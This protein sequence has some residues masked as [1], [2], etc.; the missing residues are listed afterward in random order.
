MVIKLDRLNSNDSELTTVYQ[1]IKN[2]TLLCANQ[3]KVNGDTRFWDVSDD[4]STIF[5]EFRELAKNQSYKV[6]G[7][8]FK[9]TIL[10]VNHITAKDSPEG[11]GGGWHVDSI[12]NQYKLFMYLTDC[13]DKSLG[14]LT[15]LTSE[16][17]W[18]DNFYILKNYLKGNKFRLSNNDVEKLECLGFQQKS[19]LA[20]SLTPFFVN[21]SF[22]HRGAKIEKSE[23]MLVTA[24][25]F[26]KIPGSIKGRI[27]KSG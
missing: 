9:H 5:Q 12:R 6:L 19:I 18:K 26:D 2:R 3:V 14:P 21:T 4:N 16:N 27:N 15:L 23:R 20:N 13:N 7:K 11:S 24:Y 1:Q 17:K 10:M 25:M 22:I 8:R